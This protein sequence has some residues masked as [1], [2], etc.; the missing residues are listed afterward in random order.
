M[1]CEREALARPVSPRPAPD[2]T[3]APSRAGV[4]RVARAGRTQSARVHQVAHTPPGQ[5]EALREG[6]EAHDA[7]GIRIVA[8]GEGDVLVAVVGEVFVGLIGHE[9]HAIVGAFPPER[10]PGRGR[11]DRATGIGWAAQDDCAHSVARSLQRG[12]ERVQ[13]RLACGVAGQHHGPNAA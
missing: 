6:E 3:T 7:V 9:P 1:M 10:A 2:A 4:A 8:G 5:P 13:V 12:A 11:Y